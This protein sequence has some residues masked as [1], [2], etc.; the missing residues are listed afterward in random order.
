M[1]EEFKGF[2]DA[3]GVEG[4]CPREIPIIG[5][6]HGFRRGSRKKMVRLEVVKACRV[7]AELVIK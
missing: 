7:V 5:V 4:D 2:F 3:R 6:T 1:G